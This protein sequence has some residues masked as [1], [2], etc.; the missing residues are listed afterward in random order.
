MGPLKWIWP[1]KV[2]CIQVR[3]TYDQP[4]AH[5]QLLRTEL[6]YQERGTWER[7]R[8]RDIIVIW[9]LSIVIP[10]QFFLLVKFSSHGFDLSKTPCSRTHK[11]KHTW[12]NTLPVVCGCWW[13][14]VLHGPASDRHPSHFPTPA[15]TFAAFASCSC[16]LVSLSNGMQ[17][18]HTMKCSYVNDFRAFWP[19]HANVVL[20]NLSTFSFQI[21]VLQATNLKEGVLF[22]LCRHQAEYTTSA[23]CIFDMSA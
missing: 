9:R 1:W 2:F 6:T 16:P 21:A 10:H 5:N 17:P 13:E 4:Q 7:G 12:K 18:R 15:H 20:H 8:F 14:A 11:H 23:E 19:A 22:E 3:V